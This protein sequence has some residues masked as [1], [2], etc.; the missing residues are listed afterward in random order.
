MQ[1]SVDQGASSS[2]RI[3]ARTGMHAHAGRFVD[4]SE[5]VVLVHDIERYVFGKRLEPRKLHAPSDDN[6][7]VAVQTQRRFG[8]DAVHQDLALLDQLLHSN[9]AYVRQLRNQPLV[10][11]LSGGIG[12]NAQVLDLAWLRQS[13]LSIQLDFFLK[14]RIPGVFCR[15][16]GSISSFKSLPFSLSAL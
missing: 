6:V 12:R 15:G 16:E 2:G 1:E 11:A 9:P 5:V 13:A 7:L 14:S 3:L 4:D 8:R 10:E